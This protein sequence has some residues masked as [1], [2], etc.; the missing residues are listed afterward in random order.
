MKIW[1]GI[2]N[3]IFGNACL[4]CL[5]SGLS[6]DPWLCPDCREEL[7]RLSHFPRRPNPDTLCLYAMTPLTKNL[8]HGLKYGNMP[9]L[10]G[11]MVNLA[12]QDLETYGTLQAWGKGLGFVP[13]PLHPARMRE[14]GYNQAEK[15]AMA[16]SR[17][18]KGEVLPVLKRK[19]FRMSQTTLSRE[20]RASNVAGAFEFKKSWPE[21]KIPIIVDDVYTTGATTGACLYA[22]EKMNL[23]GF[24]KVCTLLYEES[25]TAR[26]DFAADNAMEWHV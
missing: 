3:F 6:L 11:Y 10:A 9:G 4:G 19:S 24:A 15:L 14:R 23:G 26:M 16:I 12:L 5:R 22:F 20:N 18:M 13:V 17:R 25:A 8:V 1:N 2:S 7:R 21:H